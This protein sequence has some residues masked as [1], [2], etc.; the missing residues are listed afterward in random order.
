MWI[1]PESGKFDK[2]GAQLADKHYSR[3]KVGSPQFM[4][5][6]QTL[7]LVTEPRDALFGWWRP[8]PRSG[9]ISMSGLDGWTCSIFR[10]TS[11]LRS[12]GLV[13][14]AEQELVARELDLGPCGKDGLLT[15]V[16]DRKVRSS[17][18]GACF[19]SAGYVVHPTKPR[20]ADK[21]KTLLWKPYCMA[22]INAGRLLRSVV[23]TR[24]ALEE[25][26]AP[27]TAAGGEVGATP[28]R[29]HCAAAAIVLQAR[30][31]GEF[32]STRVDG[33]SHWFNRVDGFDIDLTAD[34]FGRRAIEIAKAGELW[35]DTR[36]RLESELN[37]QTRERA[38]LLS[39]RAKL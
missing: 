37:G 31:G 17:N 35:P 10:N 9:L 2:G 28:S 12:S 38:A 1:V 34:Q 6:G 36:V 32:V 13:L 21:K 26:F 14:V 11:Q 20:S 25:A 5:P 33:V 39:R 30:V 19:K 27:D 22:G 16:W 24:R 15:Y 4:P 3:R 7:I 29:G 8:H 18:P 23:K